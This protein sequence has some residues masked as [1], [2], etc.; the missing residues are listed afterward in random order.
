MSQRQ[1]T[2]SAKWNDAEGMGA[3]GGYRLRGFST[4]D[5]L[6]TDTDL[7]HDTMARSTVQLSKHATALLWRRRPLVAYDRRTQILRVPLGANLP[8]LYE[9]AVVGSSGI[10]PKV[11]SGCLEYPDV[12]PEIAGHIGYLLTN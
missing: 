11:V 4:D 9:R 10:A 5:F 7:D 2:R 8:G 6:R 12:T 3:L 1:A